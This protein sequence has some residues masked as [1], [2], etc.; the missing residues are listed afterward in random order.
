MIISIND[1]DLDLEHRLVVTMLTLVQCYIRLAL[2]F[3]YYIISI[4]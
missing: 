1:H 4:N 3:H 2:L